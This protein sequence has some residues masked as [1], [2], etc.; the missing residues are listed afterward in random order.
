MSKDANVYF[1]GS[2]YYRKTCP[3]EAHR[4]GRLTFRRLP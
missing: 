1:N 2:D 4:C 3:G